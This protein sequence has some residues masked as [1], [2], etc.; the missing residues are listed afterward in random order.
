MFF[1]E[2][3]VYFV[4]GV[5]SVTHL[6]YQA[7]DGKVTFVEL[8]KVIAVRSA[9]SCLIIVLAIQMISLLFGKSDVVAFTIIALVGGISYVALTKIIPDETFKKIKQE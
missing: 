7:T 8:L 9:I 2:L 5:V 4:C 6:S 3:A 1:L